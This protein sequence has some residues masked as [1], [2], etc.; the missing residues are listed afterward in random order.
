MSLF[1][2]NPSSIGS[3]LV[4]VNVSDLD[5]FLENMLSTVYIVIVKIAIHPHPSPFFY[6]PKI[7]T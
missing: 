5:V 1:K 7:S 2:S 6:L 3:S 4:T